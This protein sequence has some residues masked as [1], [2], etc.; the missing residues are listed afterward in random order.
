MALVEEMMAV[1]VAGHLELIVEL[2]QL[3]FAEESQD[4]GK[5]EPVIA[6]YSEEVHKTGHSQA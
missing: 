1:E 5:E 2:Q 6:G 4:A 3:Y